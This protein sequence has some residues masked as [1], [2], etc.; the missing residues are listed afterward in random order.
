MLNRTLAAGLLAT[1]VYAATPI[2]LANLAACPR[3]C[4]EV[5][6]PVVRALAHRPFNRRKA[7]SSRR[8]ASRSCGYVGMTGLSFSTSCVDAHER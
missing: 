4:A 7:R 2:A 3:G 5:A 1:S 8:V 6:R